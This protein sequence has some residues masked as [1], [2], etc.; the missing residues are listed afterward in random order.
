MLQEVD[1]NNPL[2]DAIAYRF[3]GCFSTCQLTLNKAYNAYKVA[4]KVD[5]NINMSEYL[6]NKLCNSMFKI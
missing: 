5:K 6:G 3:A 2:G 1:Q 4:S